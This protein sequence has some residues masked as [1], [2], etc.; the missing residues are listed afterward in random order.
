MKDKKEAR[1]TRTVV[2]VMAILV[3]AVIGYA[4]YVNV[5]VK[6]TYPQVYI[7]KPYGGNTTAKVVFTEYSDFQCPACGYAEPIIRTLRA[8]YRDTIA[9]RYVHFPLTN[10]H[11]NA[12][13][14]AEASEC[15][16]DQGKFWEYHDKLFENQRDLGDPL[17]IRIAEELNLSITSFQA[18]LDTEAKKE[19]VLNDLKES[20]SKDLKG[21]PSFFV[22]DRLVENY[23]YDAIK[24]MIDEEL[25]K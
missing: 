1:K 15:A 6:E 4:V 11:E 21:T 13:R 16:N 25:K 10:I 2:I 14:A 19:T 7:P 23:T 9:F 3:L 20:M 22:N 17:Y 8:E 18:C 12:F 5:F 24:S